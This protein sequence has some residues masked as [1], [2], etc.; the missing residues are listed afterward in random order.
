MCLHC[1]T[2]VGCYSKIHTKVQYS[3][4][5]TSELLYEGCTKQIIL[6]MGKTTLKKKF[7]SQRKKLRLLTVV[8]LAEKIRRGCNRLPISC[9]SLASASGLMKQQYRGSCY[10]LMAYVHLW[11][12]AQ[13]PCS[14]TCSWGWGLVR[15][16]SAWPVVGLGLRSNTP[17]LSLT[18]SWG[19]GLIRKSKAWPRGSYC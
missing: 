12:A 5:D 11:S 17:K 8:A 19:W 14:L 7:I 9:W 13:G 4:A 15:K 2:T 18:C 16:S 3:F 10:V 6:Y 1:R